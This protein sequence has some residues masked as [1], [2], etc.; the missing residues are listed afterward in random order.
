VELSFNE[1]PSEIAPLRIVKNEISV[2]GSRLQTGRF[3]VVIDHI[4]RG[5]LSLSGFVTR[6]YPIDQMAEAFDYVDKNN[7][8][9]RKVIISFE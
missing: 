3:P 8:S 7:A 9:V 6:S 5:E 1:I 2:C 4:R